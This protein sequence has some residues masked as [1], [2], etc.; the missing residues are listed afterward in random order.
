VKE[1]FALIYSPR[2]ASVTD[3]V[4][5]RPDGVMQVMRAVLVSSRRLGFAGLGNVVDGAQ[6]KAQERLARLV[7]NTKHITNTSSGHDMHNESQLVI[8]TIHK[9]VEVRNGL[10]SLPNSQRAG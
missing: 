3:L 6:K 9:V 5:V 8:N 2:R 7:P 10:L 4:R 1:N